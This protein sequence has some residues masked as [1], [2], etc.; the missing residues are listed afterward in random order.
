[1]DGKLKCDHEIQKTAH[2]AGGGGG[3]DLGREKLSVGILLGRSRFF[4]LSSILPAGLGLDGA[5]STEALGDGV[6]TCSMEI[7]E[8]ALRPKLSLFAILPRF[9]DMF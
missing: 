4:L 8:L 2:A 3:G 5:I 9:C 1:M 7:P 6:V